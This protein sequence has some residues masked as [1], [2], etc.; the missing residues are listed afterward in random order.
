[1]ARN[2]VAGDPPRS[3]DDG[4]AVPLQEH[5]LHPSAILF[6]SFSALREMTSLLLLAGTSGWWVRLLQDSVL[7]DSSSSGVTGLQITGALLALVVVFTVAKAVVAYVRFRYSYG[8]TELI[9][10][11]GGVFARQERHIPYARIHGVEVVK[12]FWHRPFNVAEVKLNTAGGI[13]AEAAMSALSEA[14]L[15]VLRRNLAEGGARVRSDL[16]NDER[17]SRS[18]PQGTLLHISTR[19]LC[20]YGLIEN[21]GLIIVGGLLSYLF[22]F[23]DSES[24][25]LSVL[26]MVEQIA[27][28]N[29]AWIAVA[30][31]F[32]VVVLWVAWTVLRYHNFTVVLREDDLRVSYGLLTRVVEVVPLHRIQSVA[33]HEGPLHQLT[34]RA[35]IGI[36]TAGSLA[37]PDEVLQNRLR[38]LAPLIPRAEVWSFVGQIAPDLSDGCTM[39]WQ[40]V[41]P[42]ATRRILNRFLPAVIAISLF[43]WW[44][45]TLPRAIGCCAVLLGCAVLYARRRVRCLGWAVRDGVVWARKGWLWR[46]VTAVPLEKVQGVA[47][48]T[49]PFDRR[50]DMA[51]L[52]ADSAGAGPVPTMRVPFLPANTANETRRQIA[53]SIPRTAFRW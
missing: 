13:G 26:R 39:E 52:A 46:R 15:G 1:M 51:W 25:Y 21:R 27:G 28:I 3:S 37:A 10:H 49:S 40:P 19:D 43:V 35:A 38:W 36:K 48:G 6:G 31:L 17:A 20:L 42:R 47:A 4:T 18:Q 45:G 7:P 14:A 34:R 44:F 2:P 8:S 29:P 32:V 41:D 9:V 24:R 33:V 23:V 22:Q 16:A 30:A 53:A 12:R 5:R 50:W 11:T